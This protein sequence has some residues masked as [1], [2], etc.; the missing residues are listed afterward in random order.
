[1]S[2]AVLV[3]V[4]ILEFPQFPF[5][6]EVQDGPGSVSCISCCTGAFGH[7]SKLLGEEQSLAL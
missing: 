6:N 7:G 4:S 1:M 2:P 5:L 3:F